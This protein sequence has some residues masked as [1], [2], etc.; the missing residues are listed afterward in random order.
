MVDIYH[1]FKLGASA[2]KVMKYGKNVNILKT[3]WKPLTMMGVYG[4]VDGACEEV[5][6]TYILKEITEELE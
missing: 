4:L 6:D 2:T 3:I 1:L 5:M